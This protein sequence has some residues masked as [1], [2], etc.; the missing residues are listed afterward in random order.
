MLP[1]RLGRI[2]TDYLDEQEHYRGDQSVGAGL[3][4][5]M[6]NEPVQG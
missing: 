2:M 5:G 4:A 1:V 3:A 6:G